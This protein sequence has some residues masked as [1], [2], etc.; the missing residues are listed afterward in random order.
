[1]AVRL[2]IKW[3]NDFASALDRAKRESK[4]IFHDFWFDG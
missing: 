3:E 1:M 2:A 4:F